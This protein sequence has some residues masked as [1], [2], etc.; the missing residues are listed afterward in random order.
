[1]LRKFTPY[2]SKNGN[3]GFAKEYE[4]YA[5]IADQSGKVYF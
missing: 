4:L 3:N 5:K 2:Q 1:M